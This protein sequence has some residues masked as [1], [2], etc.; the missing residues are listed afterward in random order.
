MH[1][2]AVALEKDGRL[3][4][5]RKIGTF[6]VIGLRDM[7]LS[8]QPFAV[9]PVWEPAAPKYEGVSLFAVEP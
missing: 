3:P 5:E 2:D 7:E 9:E 4:R 1:V 8:E 6:K